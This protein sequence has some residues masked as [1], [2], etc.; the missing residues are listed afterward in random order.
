MNSKL[1]FGVLGGANIARMFV[2]GCAP[3]ERVEIAAIASRDQGRADAM[4]KELGIKRTLG[5]YEALLADPDI[6]AIYLPLPNALH[7]AWA[8]KAVEVG[9]HVL[10][11]KPLAMTTTETKAMFAAADRHGVI[12]REGYPYMAQPQTIALRQM[13]RDGA[14]G[15]LKLIRSTFSVLFKDPANIRLMPDLGGGALYDAGSY[16]A[17][18][19]R[20]A[21]GHRPKWV[22]ATWQIDGNGVDVTTLANIEFGNGLF[23]QL[24]CSFD[25]AY[26]RSAS[27][28]GDGGIIETNYL[29]HPPM[30]GPPLLQIRRG[31]TLALPLE[32]LPV[33]DGN[34][35]RLEAEEFAALVAGEAGWHGAS[36]EES[37]D[38]ALILDAIRASAPTGAWVSLP[39]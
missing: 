29:N 3:S 25:A 24:S 14:I 28:A 7:A 31:T 20:L 27:I 39:E 13:L 19:I 12:L 11:E 38:I 34:G 18:L 32:P 33:P 8:I 2:A 10:C 1:R 30:G 37:V 16:A 9:K 21:A 35:F 17:S 36:P 22:Q 26:F 23:A 6:D 15:P 4:A 5:S